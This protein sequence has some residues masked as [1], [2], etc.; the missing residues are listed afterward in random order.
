M[1][2]PVTRPSRCSGRRPRVADQASTVSSAMSGSSPLG[3]TCRARSRA[4]PS[5]Q[6]DVSNA[7]TVCSPVVNVLGRVQQP[8][9]GSPWSAMLLWA[10][11]AAWA[12]R[13]AGTERPYRR[14]RR[15]WR[16]CPGPRCCVWVRI[17][18]SVVGVRF[19]AGSTG[20]RDQ[21]QPSGTACAGSCPAGLEGGGAVRGAGTAGG[22]RWR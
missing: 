6:N 1:S 2:S 22:A 12:G 20:C 14:G 8:A 3:C 7:A 10:V 17:G 9:G 19:R 15:R 11:S 21:P 5:R 13:S 16:C 18:P 4:A